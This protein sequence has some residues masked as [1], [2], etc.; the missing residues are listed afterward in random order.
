MQMLVYEYMS[1]GTLQDHLSGTPY[2]RALS[3]PFIDLTIFFFLS[4]LSLSLSPHP[5]S[6]LFFFFFFLFSLQKFYITF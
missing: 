6:C 1:N 5:P 2:I 4:V 3:F